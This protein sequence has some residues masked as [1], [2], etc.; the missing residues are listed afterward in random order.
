MSKLVYYVA[1]V[2][3]LALLACGGDDATEVPA[4]TVASEPTTAPTAMVEP[5][6]TPE[7]TNTPVPT[8]EPE[9]TA[10]PEPTPTAA[11]MVPAPG[12]GA[13][14]P[15]RLDD[16]LNVAGE[17]SEAELACASGVAD[18]GRLL[19][20][21][22]APEQAEPDELSQLI[23]CLEE[24]TVLRLFIT[25]LVGLEDP[26]SEEA[27]ACIRGGMEGVDA[28]GVMLSGMAGDEQTAMMGSMS[29]FLLILTCLNDEEFAAAAPALGVPVDEREGMLCLV[30]E[31]GGPEV[32]AAA[33]SGQ[34]E[35]AMMAM[36]GAA[37]TCGLEMDGGPAPGPA[38]TAAP[39]TTPDTGD[40]SMTQDNLSG[41]V[42]LLSDS[43]RTCLME[44]GIAPEWLQDPS[45]VEAATP[46]QE[47]Q[48]LGCFKDETVM[49]FFLSGLV[50]DPSQLSEETST[51]IRTEMEG[52]DLRGVMLAGTAGDEQA[53]MVGGM[54]AM[55]LTISCLND[56]D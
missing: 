32:L 54:S 30:G 53:A 55:F 39:Q 33:F 50:G 18:L 15:L 12:A 20:I 52:I 7:P 28:R 5:T 9:P 47:V 8:S 1:L 29:A 16:P 42:S 49:D 14:R 11:P 51:C 41:I 26:L 4:E 22:S 19:Q 35:G 25:T 24:E 27:S 56:E 45:A 36:F 21:F 10:I 40:T 2:A 6:A 34:D 13:I 43:E 37:I 3:L 31:I 17:L 44:A 23:T 48:V 38:P 46:Q